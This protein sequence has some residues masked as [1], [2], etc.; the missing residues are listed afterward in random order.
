MLSMIA[1]IVSVMVMVYVIKYEFVVGCKQC[2]VGC[3]QCVVVCKQC[4]VGV[5]NV[6][7]F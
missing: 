3:K 5:S 1:L 7:V 2:V 4:V 6:L